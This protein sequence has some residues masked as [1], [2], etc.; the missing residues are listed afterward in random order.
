M[1]QAASSSFRASRTLSESHKR[2]I[3]VLRI[4]SGAIAQPPQPRQYEISEIA[5]LTNMEDE[6]EVQRYLLI[7]EGQKL[8]TPYPRGDFTSTRWQITRRGVKA[9]RT[10]V[11]SV[12][13]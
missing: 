6:R 9:M 2:Q 8:V 3:E 11:R 12:L 10:I 7:L 4:L 13:Q 5:Q 1:T